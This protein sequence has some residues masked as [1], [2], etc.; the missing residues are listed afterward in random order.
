MIAGGRYLVNAT[1]AIQAGITDIQSSDIGAGRC[2]IWTV[3]AHRAVNA[4]RSL[5]SRVL[6]DATFH[7]CTAGQRT[8]VSSRANFALPGNGR[9]HIR[10]KSSW[11]ILIGTASRA[12]VM[13]W[14]CRNT[15]CQQPVA[16]SWQVATSGAR[17]RCCRQ[18][19]GRAVVAGGTNDVRSRQSRRGACISLCAGSALGDALQVRPIAESTSRTWILRRRTCSR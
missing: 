17:S 18:T 1:S 3:P 8:I 7:R 15:L 14:W 10:I 13:S 11:A 4:G 6:S 2:P 5:L 16:R 9:I 19:A 12:G